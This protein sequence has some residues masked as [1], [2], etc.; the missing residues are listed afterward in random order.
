MDLSLIWAYVVVVLREL[1]THKFKA[2]ACFSVVSLIVLAVGMNAQSTFSSSA[3]IFA[4]NQNILKPLLAQSAQ[5]SK[6]QEHIRVVREAINA[7]SLLRA[8]VEAQYD[9]SEITSAAELDR[10][11]NGIRNRLDVQGLG[12]SYVKIG[13]SD[14]TPER[15]FDV[16]NAVIDRFIKESSETRRSESKEAFLFIDN[17]VKQYKEKLVDAEEQLKQFKA[18]N[19]DGR[20]ADVD[21]RISGLR[22]SL[23]EMKI[24][25]DEERSRVEALKSQLK[26]ENRQ[27][28]RQYKS[29]VFRDRLA[30]LQSRIDTLL[31]SYQESYPDVVNLRLQMEDIT[32]AMREAQ[33]EETSVVP[34]GNDVVTN[35]FYEELRSKLSGA[36]VSLNTRL[37]RMTA[38]ERLLGQEFER[39]KRI[40]TQQAQLSELTRDYNVTKRIYDDMLERK[41]KARLSMTL[42][43][44]GQGVSYKIQEPPEYPLNPEG[45]R[46]LHY[47]LIGPFLGGL[48]AVGAVIGYVLLD[49]RVRFPAE[50]SHQNS[51]LLLAVI[52]HVKTPFTQR[53]ARGDFVLLSVLSLALLVGYGGIAYGHRAGLF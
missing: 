11:V 42:S 26:K 53:I 21:A 43:I 7:P 33:T 23:E 13:Y 22:A 52:P 36:E 9:D 18:D 27:A 50:L 24:D 19:F 44:E 41:E 51:E 14:N 46:F 38:T 39:R 6:I 48:L 49:P 16:L 35:P 17:Q 28:A 15:T 47:V 29:D 45:I 40:A 3:T 32:S 34:N 4:D 8:V 2:F 12:S 10:I 30:A 37:R 1:W 5:V 25:V 20:E 31:L